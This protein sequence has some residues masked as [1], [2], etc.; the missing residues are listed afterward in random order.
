MA[1]RSLWAQLLL[2]GLALGVEQTCVWKDGSIATGYA[3]CAN[4]SVA[5]VA[6]AGAALWLIR[7]YRKQKSRFKTV[8]VGTAQEYYSPTLKIQTSK[9]C[10]VR[11]GQRDFQGAPKWMGKD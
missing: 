1:R 9:E 7:L 5:L 3:P 11:K 8:S 4:S 6:C 10:T 2:V